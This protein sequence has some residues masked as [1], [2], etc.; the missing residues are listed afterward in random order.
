MIV[1]IHEGY[2]KD[3]LIL[4]SNNPYF[5]REFGSTHKVSTNNIYRELSDVS[6]RINNKLGE[7]CFFEMD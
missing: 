4:T 7:E 3:Y 1:T 5:I 6:E 2:D